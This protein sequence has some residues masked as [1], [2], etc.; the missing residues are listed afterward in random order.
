M[1]TRE[2]FVLMYKNFE[3]LSF[4]VDYVEERAKI[5]K[6]LEHIDKAPWGEK[7][8][9]EFELHQTP[10]RRFIAKRTI[11]KTRT[12]YE[13]IIKATGFRNGFELSFQGHGLS[14]SNHFWYK[15]EG[16]NLRYEDINFFTNKWDDSFAKAVLAQDYETLKHCDLNV[17]DIVTAGW[18]VKGWIYEESGPKLYKLGIN[19]DHSEEALGEVLAS[20]I[21][22]QLFNDGEVLEYELRKVGDRY[23]SVSP[24]MIGIDEDLAPLSNFVDHR[25]YTIYRQKNIDKELAKKF[26]EAIKSAPFPGLFDFFV[27]IACVRDLCFVSDLHFENISLI[28]NSKTGEV[29]IAPLYDLGGAFGSSRSGQN[30]LSKIDKST[31]ILVYYLFSDLDPDWD[32]SWYNPDKLIGFEDEIRKV[33]SKSAFYTP[34][35]IDCIVQVYKHQKEVLDERAKNSLKNK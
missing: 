17:P 35:I 27:K 8:S 29:R 1:K 2:T 30:I 5:I 23:A 25:I 21:A 16:E 13:E 14:L 26:Y 15:R 31:F 12:G 33:L 22:K 28:R 6:I 3:V 32:Y 20:K 9:N 34:E 10:L 7:D 11:P 24:V 4:E 18:G 19:K